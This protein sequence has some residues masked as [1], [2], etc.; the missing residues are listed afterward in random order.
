MKQ[1]ISA[2]LASSLLIL[3]SIPA[4]ASIE[5]L[6]S[7]EPEFHEV[8]TLKMPDGGWMKLEEAKDKKGRIT[9][10]H[11]S[12]DTDG[13]VG[14]YFIEYHKNGIAKSVQLHTKKSD[15]KFVC[16]KD[17]DHCDNVVFG[18]RLLRSSIEDQQ[19]NGH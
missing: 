3:S 11:A 13:A 9:D 6:G 17:R 16:R 14:E 2:L 12:F 15:A 4:L 10:E 7:R 18:N 8:G 5:S 19:R 1:S